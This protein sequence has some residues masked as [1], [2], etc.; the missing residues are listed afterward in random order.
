[1]FVTEQAAHARCGVGERVVGVA[2]LGGALESAVL[3]E[4]ARVHREDAL[5]DDVEAEVPGLDD[6]GVD[7]A[8][9]DLVDAVAAARGSSTARGRSGCAARARIGEWPANVEA[10]EVVGLALIPVGG[11]DEVDDALDLAGARVAREHAKPVGR[12]EQRSPAR[13]LCHGW[14]PRRRRTARRRRGLV[15]RSPARRAAARVRSRSQD[16]PCEGCRRSRARAAAAR[17]R[18]RMRASRCRE[19]R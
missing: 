5:S 8:D 18:S 17:R 16:A 6:A 15:R 7:R 13:A 4:Q 1:M 9:R 3:V 10:V 14:W 19:S 11:L 12:D 2:A